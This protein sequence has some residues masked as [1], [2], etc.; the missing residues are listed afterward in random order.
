MWSSPAQKR[1]RTSSEYSLL[2]ILQKSRFGERH[3][4]TVADDDVIEQADVDQRE[5]FLDSLGD[6]FVGLT[7]FG[8]AGRVI[9]RDDDRGRIALQSQL[10]DF[11]RMHAGAV[12]RAAKQFLKLNQAMALIEV[13]TAK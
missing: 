13:E 9:V 4:G 6:Q 11:A 3:R 10:D 7:R 8:D 12:D 2:H 5:R 1:G